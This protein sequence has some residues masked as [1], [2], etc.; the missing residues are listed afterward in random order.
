[1]AARDNTSV[2]YVFDNKP[3]TGETMPVAPG[4]HWLRL[5]LPFDLNH[6]NVWLLEDGT[7]RRRYV[8]YPNASHGLP[9]GEILRDT[10]DWL[11]RYLPQS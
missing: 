10:A 1:M 4:I 7:E 9:R 8:V 6:I 3:A 2:R 11:D 5:P